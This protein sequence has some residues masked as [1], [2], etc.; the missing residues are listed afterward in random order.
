[1]PVTLPIALAL[2]VGAEG[3]PVL[4][5]HGIWNSGAQMAAIQRR[6][7][8]AG[9]RAESIDLTPADGSAPILLLAEQV[10]RAAGELAAA[11]G[12]D[13][14]DL[15]GFSMGALVSRAYVQRLGGRARVRRFVS[16]S[17][18]HGGTVTAR[19]SPAA[20]GRDMRPGSALLRDLASDRDPWGPVEV[21]ALFTPYDLMVFPADTARLAGARSTRTFPVLLHRWMVTDERVLAAVVEVLTTAETSTAQTEKK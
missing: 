7:R 9:R 16:I 17:G 11:S 8:G 15:V 20:G 5:V 18:P 21:H 6:L 1:M 13:R 10:A 2:A 14:I 3:P 19:L 12:A 4:L